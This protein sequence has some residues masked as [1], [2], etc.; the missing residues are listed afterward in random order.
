MISFV[1]IAATIQGGGALFGQT[2]AETINYIKSSLRLCSNDQFEMKAMEVREV[3]FF[4]GDTDCK[5]TYRIQGMTTENYLEFNLKNVEVYSVTKIVKTAKDE[6]TFIYSL[7][8][9]ARTQ[10]SFIKKNNY[11][12]IGPEM[13][14]ENIVSQKKAQGLEAA[15]AHLKRLVTGQRTFFK[16]AE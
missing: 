15:F 6:N 7:Q 9:K 13:I 8:V 10:D 5:I 4:N 16:T 14:V 1:A 3:D 2:K 12:I 11:N